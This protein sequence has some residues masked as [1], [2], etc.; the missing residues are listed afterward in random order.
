MKPITLTLLLLAVLTA[1]TIQAADDPAAA[2]ESDAILDEA[3]T[4]EL[5]AKVDAA[6]DKALAYLA[7][8]QEKDGSWKSSNLGCASTSVAVMSFMAKGHQPGEGEYGEVI[9]KGI[10]YVIH[11]QKP[12]GEFAQGGRMYAHG[13]S[14]LMLAEAVGQT[15]GKQNEQVRKA[16]AKGVKLIL[17]AQ[18]IPKPDRMA[19]GWRYQ[20][21]S[22]DS[23]LSV[24]GWQLMALRAAKN[25][26]AEVPADA[27]EKAV[28]YVK[29]S[30]TK[31]GG[32]SYTPQSGATNH[33]RASTGV[34]A[35]EICGQHHAKE[36][37]AAGDWLL[38]HPYRP[39]ATGTGYQYYTMYYCAQA[40][41][42]LGGKY[43]KAFWPTFA[44]EVVK[45]QQDDGSFPAGVSTERSAGPGYSTGMAILALSVR[46]RLLPIYQ[47]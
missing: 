17:D 4:P 33:A 15:S 31:G 20:P 27:I 22:R 44:E 14:T 13:I 21:T 3:T 23:D 1:A 8:I 26:G 25:A 32:F 12:N 45:R 18:K 35:L 16:L 5:D 2:D 34:L 24:T 39:Y 40:M 28:E 41:F 29:R 38:E 30:A 10:D 36:S 6:T 11:Q 19:G 42:Q 7:K 47:R 37:L 43:W 9:V 46:Y